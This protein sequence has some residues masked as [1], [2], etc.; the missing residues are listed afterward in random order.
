MMAGTVSYACVALRRC[1]PSPVALPCTEDRIEVAVPSLA[2]G[3][4]LGFG[5]PGSG[6]ILLCNGEGAEGC[7]S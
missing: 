2:G 6:A 3:A 4:S 5:A 7:G 1:R